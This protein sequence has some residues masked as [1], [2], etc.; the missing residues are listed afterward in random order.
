MKADPQKAQTP[1]LQRTPHPLT[2]DGPGTTM[3]PPTL[4]LFA[5][6]EL[7]SKSK[8]QGNS[9]VIQREPLTCEPGNAN[10]N[11]APVHEG[12]S[13]EADPETSKW[14][15][16]A[17]EFNK[18]FTSILHAFEP[19]KEEAPATETT[20]A[21]TT[22]AEGGT[23]AAAGTAK[24]DGATG[25]ATTATPAPAPKAKPKAKMKRGKPGTQSGA[26]MDYLQL[27][28]LFT[29]GQREKLMSYMETGQIPERLFNGDEVGATTAQQRL[30]MSAQI[31]SKGKYM[32]G[33][34]EQGVHARMCYHFV[35]IVHH[36]AGASPKMSMTYTGGNAHGVMGNFDHTGDAVFGTAKSKSVFSGAK[37]AKDSLPED[38]QEGIGPIPEDSNHSKGSDK[39]DDKIA[40]G[41]KK[42]ASFH[43]RAGLPWDRFGEIKPGD[44]LWYYNANGSAGGA[45]SVIFSRWATEAQSIGGVNYRQA[46]CYSQGQ[47]K[48]GGR[49]HTANLGD[50]YY[51][52]GKTKVY[53]ITWVT[54]VNEDA[55]PA[56]SAD[57][58]LPKG[59]EK[60]E[61]KLGKSNEDYIKWVER[62]TKKPVDVEAVKAA[63]RKETDAL[64]NKLSPRLTLGQ[65][66]MLREINKSDS[67]EDLVK[68][69]QRMREMSSNSELLEK[70]TKK[71]F[72]DKLNDKHA[73]AA[74]KMTDEEAA[75]NAKLAEIDGELN[76]ML[77]KL[78]AVE[79]KQ[80]ELVNP[81]AEM[82]V[83]Y[84]KAGKMKREIRALKRK[85]V[86]KDDPEMKKQV[87][88]RQEVL[89]KIEE[90]KK[91]R[92]KYFADK[93]ALR[94]EFVALTRSARKIKWKRDAVT[95]KLGKARKEMPFGMVH[96]GGLK[97]QKKIKVTGKLKEIF[98][99]K[100]MKEFLIH[101]AE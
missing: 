65:W 15:S 75:A 21:E 41:K 93:K 73:E 31:L 32:P 51:N 76:P 47:P 26:T 58:I 16:F 81:T 69:L 25:E 2:T 55:R 38:E 84:T 53:P 14:I 91:A 24:A 70:N 82:K 77:E 23:T 5:E 79:K 92:T 52:D 72:D 9:Q 99:Y 54:R 49:E 33:S 19:A 10:T 98:S 57:E 30:L 74:K 43:R 12:P 22:A 83:L 61:A 37:N 39:E 97:T 95:K 86:A 8:D 1:A 71:T 45:H 67:I 100:A 68:L 94:K 44:W 66:K 34:F 27:Q 7:A 88:A 17:Y 6:P 78:K 89:D 59:S 101:D 40:A 80:G 60:K 11:A 3:S 35:H 46:I 63:L 96:S 50:K 62:K 29:D 18:E 87:D 20:A 13:C 42:S 36:Y 28:Q 4:Q 90:L 64:I 48:S 56:Q 85:K